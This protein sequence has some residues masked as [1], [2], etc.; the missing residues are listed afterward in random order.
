MVTTSNPDRP[1]APP[2][3]APSADASRAPAAADLP[4][5]LSRVERYVTAGLA[6]ALEEAGGRL[7]EWRVLALLAEAPGR[8]MSEIAEAVFL[9]APSLT[10]LVDRMVAANLLHRRPDPADRRRVLVHPTE[11]GRAQHARLS[12]AA[13]A[14]RARIESLFGRE[15]AALL[16]AL[17]AKAAAAA[18]RC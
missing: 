7:E 3:P 5:L 12:E 6:A 8:T 18:D 16:S 2:A 11:R 14:E 15:E 17:L 13:A 9:P 1:A 4:Y 10:K